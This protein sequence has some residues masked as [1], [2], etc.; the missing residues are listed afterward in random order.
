MVNG[1]FLSG[2]G[3]HGLYETDRTNSMKRKKKILILVM[4]GCLSW[5]MFLVLQNTN[6]G[7]IIAVLGGVEYYSECNYTL[8]ALENEG[9]LPPSFRLLLG[10]GPSKSGMLVPCLFFYDLDHHESI[11][12]EFAVPRDWTGA[13]YLDLTRLEFLLPDGKHEELIPHPSSPVRFYFGEYENARRFLSYRAGRLTNVIQLSKEQGRA[14]FYS[15]FWPAPETAT[16]IAEG[17]FHLDVR[18]EDQTFR[19][20][21]RWKIRKS[22]GIRKLNFE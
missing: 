16:L 14:H 18:K 8:D 6:L 5:G 1:D 13:Q 19:Q 11:L 9:D 2:T 4:L 17:T 7:Y 20:V 15:S 10:G 12:V 21:S 3:N 22:H